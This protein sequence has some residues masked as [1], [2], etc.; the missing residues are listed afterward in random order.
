[1]D[2][3]VSK[4][5]PGEQVTLETY[6]KQAEDW[7]VTRH[8]SHF[9]ESEM[10][11]FYRHL[12]IG[13]ILEIG[14][15]S[16]R[17]ARELI[18]LGY[19]YTGT[20]ISE[21]F[22][23]IARRENPNAPFFHQSVYDLSFPEPPGFDGF[24]ASAVLLHV[25]KSRIDEALQAIIRC[26]KPRAVGFISL[27]QGKTEGVLEEEQSGKTYR[28]LFSFWMPYEFANVLER[29]H[30]AILESAV[31]VADNTTWLTYIVRCP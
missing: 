20:D 7:S 15:G 4:L 13:S 5:T 16:G 11:A 1:M 17:D 6:E 3:K 21:S 28:R 10:T 26:M 12:P 29:H 24:W 23:K 2:K 30:I 27:K 14:S 8:N 31:R 19:D 18:D 9:W 22:I 25:P